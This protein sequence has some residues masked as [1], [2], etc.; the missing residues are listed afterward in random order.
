MLRTSRWA[1]RGIRITAGYGR[2]ALA[3][4]GTTGHTH[5][6]FTRAQWIY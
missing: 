2:A 5:Q 6:Y 1:N 3:T 4:F